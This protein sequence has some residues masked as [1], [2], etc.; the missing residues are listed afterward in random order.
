ME[1]EDAFV[2]EPYRNIWD[3]AKPMLERG[4]AGDVDH[5]VET[6]K[7]ILE[8]RGGIPIDLDVLVPVAMMHDIGHIAIL[9]EHFRYVTG[10]E[11]IVNGKLVHMLTGAKVA[12][13]VLESAGYDTGKSGEIVD[14]ISIHDADALEGIDHDRFY[15]TENKKI[16]HDFDRL[17]RFSELRLKN[18][19]DLYSDESVVKKMLDESLCTFIFPE[20][21]ELAE[22][23]LRNL[24]Q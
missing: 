21:R 13:E 2:P 6:V 20:F 4:R 16:F 15:D 1:Y 23:R 10:P 12:R 14:I 18:V 9:P 17:D 24:Y 11:K 19:R 7:M 8:Y 3:R 22:S 5:A